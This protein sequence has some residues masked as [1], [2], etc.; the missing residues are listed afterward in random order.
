LRAIGALGSHRDLSESV[1]AVIEASIEAQDWMA[2]F[3]DGQ[4]RP[5]RAM[6]VAY[7]LSWAGRAM[8]FVP[9]GSFGGFTV[10]HKSFYHS[11]RGVPV[12]LV[13]RP[14]TFITRPS[15]RPGDR[16]L[17]SL[18][19]P[20]SRVAALDAL[21]TA[22]ETGTAPSRCLVG[23]SPTGSVFAVDVD[24]ELLTVAI[25][26]VADTLAAL[27]PQLRGEPLHAEPGRS[28]WNCNHRSACHVGQSW[29]KDQPR[30]RS[31]LLL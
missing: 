13:S 20:D 24:R 12:V 21:V 29:M 23:Y 5:S 25:E 17:L 30:R 4:D 1:A 22:L 16:V 8:T 2:S 28:C 7:A 31:G 18:G 26:Y 3:L 10:L 19:W 9:W 11:P 6:T 14:D 15:A 27:S